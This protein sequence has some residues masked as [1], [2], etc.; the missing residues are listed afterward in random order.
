MCAVAYNNREEKK[1]RC[2]A[3]GRPINNR[4]NQS[5]AS[6]CITTVICGLFLAMIARVVSKPK[7]SFF[8]SIQMLDV[9]IENLFEAGSINGMFNFH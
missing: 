5:F 6:H 7:Y 1:S 4:K 9:S 3:I 2:N 8:F